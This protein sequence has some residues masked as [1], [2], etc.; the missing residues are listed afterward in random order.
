MMTGMTVNLRCTH[1]GMAI[2]RNHAQYWC[3]ECGATI[4]SP[5]L[6]QYP[7]FRWPGALVTEL[8]LQGVYHR[9]PK[10]ADDEVEAEFEEDDDE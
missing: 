10:P 5:T 9:R 3:G 6:A 7:G 2:W 4:S 1:V 8:D